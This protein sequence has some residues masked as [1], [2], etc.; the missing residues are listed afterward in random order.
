MNFYVFV[1]ED[2]LKSWSLKAAGISKNILAS[3]VGY[4]LV[5]GAVFG[6]CVMIWREM[7]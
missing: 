1:F 7:K 4:P 6:V 2:Q 5:P 3:S